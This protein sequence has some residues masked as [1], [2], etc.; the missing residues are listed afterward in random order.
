MQYASLYNVC[1]RYVLTCLKL[2]VT[3]YIFFKIV[4]YKQISKNVLLEFNQ[5][6]ILK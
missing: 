2:K 3:G 4:R 1:S 6:V 5:R